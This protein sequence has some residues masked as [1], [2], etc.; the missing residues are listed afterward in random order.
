MMAPFFLNLLA[1]SGSFL[2]LPERL[3]LASEVSSVFFPF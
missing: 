1:V 3:F 2:K